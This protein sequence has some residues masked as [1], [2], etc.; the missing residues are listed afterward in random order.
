MKIN[1]PKSKIKI[2]CT[3]LRFKPKFK[4]KLIWSEIVNSNL[5]WSVLM[6]LGSLM[7]DGFYFNFSYFTIFVRQIKSDISQ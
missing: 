7:N 3:T 6:N 2:V 4:L 1:S 5:D